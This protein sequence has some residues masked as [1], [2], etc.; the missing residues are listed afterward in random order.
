[1]NR[2]AQIRNQP[3]VA[4]FGFLAKIPIKFNGH[5]FGKRFEQ[6]YRETA[7]STNER[8]NGTVARRR[9]YLGDALPDGFSS[10]KRSG[11]AKRS[12]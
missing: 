5:N 10:T 9:R 11:F 2:I 1:M 12:C 8:A 7:S 4:A 3:L 6:Y